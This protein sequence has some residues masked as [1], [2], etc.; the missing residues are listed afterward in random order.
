VKEK[1]STPADF[2]TRR[3]AGS[4]DCDENGTGRDG[5]SSRAIALAFLIALLLALT[6]NSTV[7]AQVTVDVAKITCRQY[8][9]GKITTPRSVANWLSGYFHGERGDTTLDHGAMTTDVVKLEAFCRK[10]H[11]VPLLEAARKLFGGR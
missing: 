8:L 3:Q 6:G 1:Q 7:Q 10:N 5:M 4:I 9:T 11:D 2:K